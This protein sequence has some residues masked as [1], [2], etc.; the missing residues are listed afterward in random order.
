MKR[1]KQLGSRLTAAMRSPR[2]R[3]KSQVMGPDSSLLDADR[4][5][6]DS[7]SENHALCDIAMPAAVDNGAVRTWSTTG[8]LENDRPRPAVM[9]SCYRQGHSDL[10]EQS[11]TFDANVP[12]WYENDTITF[13]PFDDVDSDV[14]CE[15]PDNLPMRST[16]DTEHHFSTLVIFV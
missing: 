1:Q 15:V 10:R 9:T 13:D 8:T 12:P 2:L 3:K 14:D 5:A 11:V 16:A 4:T 7:N 6:I